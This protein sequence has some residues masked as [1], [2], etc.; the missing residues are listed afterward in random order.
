MKRLFQYT[1]SSDCKKDC[2]KWFTLSINCVI[3]RQSFFILLLLF[4][5][6]F[7]KYL[8]YFFFI[9]F[10]VAICHYECS[11]FII[12]PWKILFTNMI[13][14]IINSW[15]YLVMWKCHCISWIQNRKSRHYF[16]ICKNIS[17][18]CFLAIS[19]PSYNFSTFS[20]IIFILLMIYNYLNYFPMYLPIYSYNS[21][22][23]EADKSVSSSDSFLITTCEVSFPT[24]HFSNITPKS[25]AFFTTKLPYN[26]K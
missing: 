3:F 5:Q 11:F 12:F 1:K 15:N 21:I 23:S 24:P 17:T 22:I 8:L 18:L 26:K 10:L 19:T 25:N 13:K 16:F 14:D 6:A 2:R 20:C 4:L 9:K 7:S